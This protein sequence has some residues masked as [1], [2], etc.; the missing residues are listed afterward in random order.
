MI[1]LS[2]LN[3]GTGGFAYM[4]YQGGNNPKIFNDTYGCGGF[5]NLEDLFRALLKT[6]ADEEIILTDNRG[7]E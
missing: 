4:E 6:Y 5:W 7:Q 3:D 1:K 2:I